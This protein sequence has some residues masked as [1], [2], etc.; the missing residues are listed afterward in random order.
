MGYILSIFAEDG[1]HA[2]YYETKEAAYAGFV[3]QLGHDPSEQNRM[4]WDNKDT[5][6]ARDDWGRSLEVFVA[7]VSITSGKQYEK[8]GRAYD[9]R[10]C[11]IDTAE[12]RKLLGAAGW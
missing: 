7:P 1:N 12:D 8:L 5:M 6:R 4:S 3:E 10:E 11:G 2:N 9:R